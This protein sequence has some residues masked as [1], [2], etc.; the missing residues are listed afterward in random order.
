MQWFCRAI[1]L[2]MISVKSYAA[3]MVKVTFEIKGNISLNKVK[4]KSFTGL[5]CEFFVMQVIG[6]EVSLTKRI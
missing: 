4:K 5:S 6:D 3:F 1:K 2:C